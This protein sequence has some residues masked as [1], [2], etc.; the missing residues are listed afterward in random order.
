MKK[1]N[2][3]TPILKI[4]LF[5]EDIVTMSTPETVDGVLEFDLGWITQE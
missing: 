4:R 3:L 5:S 1:C 2:Y